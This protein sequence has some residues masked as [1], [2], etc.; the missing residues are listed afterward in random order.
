MEEKGG[1]G[2]KYSIYIYPLPST[3]HLKTIA[4]LIR[5]FENDRNYVC[6]DHVQFLRMRDISSQSLTISRNQ[7]LNIVLLWF[8]LL[9]FLSVQV[10]GGEKTNCSNILG[11]VVIFMIYVR[12]LY[13]GKLCSMILFLFRFNKLVLVCFHA[14][15]A[16]ARPS[17]ASLLQ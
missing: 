11:K 12:A 3:N 10:H 2:N 8:W 4:N 14:H 7:L 1:G 16:D 9:V 17:S 6:W 5:L 13:V 15:Y